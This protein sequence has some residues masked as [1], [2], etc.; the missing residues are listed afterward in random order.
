MT[1]VR[2]VTASDGRRA[3]VECVRASGPPRPFGSAAALAWQTTFGL[4][5]R[6]PGQAVG[7][8]RWDCGPVLA[9]RWLNPFLFRIGLIFPEIPSNFQNLHKFI[10]NLE[11]CKIIFV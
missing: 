11:K 7:Y 1:A 10:E 8:E 9:Q 6:T 2:V 5:A 3:H 4:W